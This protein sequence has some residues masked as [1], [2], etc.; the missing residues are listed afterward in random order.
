M[1]L[2]CSIEVV[3][4]DCDHACFVLDPTD[5]EDDGALDPLAF[6]DVK[7]LDPGHDA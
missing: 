7:D 6:R 5:P 2:P 3:E 4:D 1:G